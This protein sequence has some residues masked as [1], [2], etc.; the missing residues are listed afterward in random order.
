MGAQADLDKT[1]EV[2]ASRWHPSSPNVNRTAAVNVIKVLHSN[3]PDKVSAEFS[4]FKP[5]VGVP[6]RTDV[7]QGCDAVG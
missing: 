1:T 6:V 5:L 7:L 2:C 3:L 4:F